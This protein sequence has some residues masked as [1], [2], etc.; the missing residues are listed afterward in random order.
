MRSGSTPPHETRL[1]FAAKRLVADAVVTLFALREG[2][3][4]V[5]LPGIDA[6]RACAARPR[7]RPAPACLGRPAERGGDSPPVG[8]D[9]RQSACSRRGAAAAQR[10]TARGRRGAAGADPGGS[11]ARAH[12]H[13]TRRDTAGGLQA[14]ARRRRGRARTRSGAEDDLR[15]SRA[16]RDRA[17]R[18]RARRGR[19][20]DR[21]CS[22][23]ACVPA[24]ADALR[25][26]PLCGAV[27]ASSGAPCPRR[28]A[29]GGRRPR[30]ARLASRRRGAGPGRRGR[31]GARGTGPPGGGAIRVRRRGGR[32]CPSRR[33]DRGRAGAAST[34]P[35]G[36]GGG[37][38]RRT[39]GRRDRVSRRA[40]RVLGSTAPSRGAT[41][42]RTDR[43]PGG[44]S[45]G[46]DGTPPG[47]GGPP[48]AGRPGTLD[49]DPRRGVCHAADPGRRGGRA[50]DRRARRGARGHGRRRRSEAA[51]RVHARLGALLCG[52]SG[53]GHPDRPGDRRLP[54]PA[55]RRARS[56]AAAALRRHVRLARTLTRRVPSGRPRD[57]PVAGRGRRWAPPVPARA[58]RLARHSGRPA[59]RRLRGGVGGTRPRDR[60]RPAAAAD[61]GAPDPDRGHGPAGHGARVPPSTR[62]RSCR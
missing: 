57:R 42:P 8:G 49:R 35:G 62:P 51:R 18:A 45:A 14:G 9:R 48:R 11:D 17:G 34:A 38:T 50:R 55:G 2:E 53:R 12:L 4:D 32:P 20:S 37:A 46:G 60:A 5:E 31:R 22:R 10:G 6:A 16:A 40:A 29:L 15:G 41:P 61:A 30:A 25:R 43:L 24:P 36:G 1:L 52:P 13:G 23:P 56:A 33:A 59:R 54:R 28:V 47:G 39:V 58:A 27:G 21:A 26:L 19:R 44:G 7:R 3:R